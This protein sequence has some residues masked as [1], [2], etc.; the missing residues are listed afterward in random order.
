MTRE[1]KMGGWNKKGDEC[2]W[3]SF[4]H[5]ISTTLFFSYALCITPSH[6]PVANSLNST[7]QLHGFNL[8]V[9]FKS[10][11]REWISGTWMSS[12]RFTWPNTQKQQ[13]ED[14][15]SQAHSR[16]FSVWYILLC[17]IGG[18]CSWLLYWVMVW[19]GTVISL[20][21]GTFLLLLVIPF[22]LFCA[23]TRCLDWC[24]LGRW[25]EKSKGLVRDQS[26]KLID[27]YNC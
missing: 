5:Y 18:S 16:V 25:I 8:K 20:L 21:K 6:S 14:G 12:G 10:Q 9:D 3:N 11:R 23:I 27:F 1:K 2:G 24:L 19:L 4:H 26:C 22:G 15:I 7:W 13:Q 17:S